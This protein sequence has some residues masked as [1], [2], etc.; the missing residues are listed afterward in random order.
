MPTVAEQDQHRIFGAMLEVAL[1]PAVAAIAS[2]P[3]RRRKMKTLEEAR[4]AVGMNRPPKSAAAAKARRG[5][6]SSDDRVATADQVERGAERSPAEAATSISR[7]ATTAD[8]QLGQDERKSLAISV[9]SPPARGAAAGP[10]C[11][12][13]SGAR[14]ARR[15]GAL[16]PVKQA[17]STSSRIGAGSSPD[18]CPSRTRR[19]RSARA[20][21]IRAC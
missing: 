14:I 10:P 19:R 8:D 21:T 2:P 11:R 5:R 6:R 3:R 20:A 13:R 7:I 15:R 17:A 9:P 18:R 12:L 16:E 1:E 4:E